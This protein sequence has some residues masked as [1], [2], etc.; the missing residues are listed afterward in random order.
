MTVDKKKLIITSG[1]AIFTLVILFFLILPATKNIR[2][3]ND[4]IYKQREA[5]EKLY[6]KAHSIRKSKQD[7]DSI[8]DEVKILDNAFY[9]KGQELEFI[10]DLELLAQKNNISLVINIRNDKEEKLGDYYEIRVDL[11]VNGN[12]P[13]ILRFLDDVLTLNFYYN[14]DQ[15]NFSN[16]KAKTFSDK[17]AE[18]L[19]PLFKSLESPIINANIS[20]ITYWK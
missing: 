14:L 10:T 16:Q 20:G 18:S 1:S 8:K 6:V 17:E 5:V 2:S 3:I 19:N 15:L 12:Y 4:D 11:N 13:D 7:Y 9:Y